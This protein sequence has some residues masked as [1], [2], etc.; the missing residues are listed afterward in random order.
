MGPKNAF[1]QKFDFTLQEDLN[2]SIVFKNFKQ[3]FWLVFRYCNEKHKTQKKC[4]LILIYNLQFQTKNLSYWGPK[5]AFSQT[6]WFTFPADL[7]SKSQ[8]LALFFLLLIF[9]GQFLCIKVE[10]KLSG[11][12]LQLTQSKN[13]SEPFLKMHSPK[14]LILLFKTIFEY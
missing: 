11:I 12:Y 3:V 7:I 10:K 1:S 2:L 4:C 6:V 8:T 14:E 9:F 5:K 13:L